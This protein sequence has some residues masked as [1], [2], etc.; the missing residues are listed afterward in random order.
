MENSQSPSEVSIETKKQ[1]LNTLAYLHQKLLS[2]Q[3]FP[4][5]FAEADKVLKLVMS[6]AKQLD[7]EIQADPLL[8]SESL[9]ATTEEKV[10]E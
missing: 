1:T 8:Q 10:S 9:N 4:E 6:M 7:A 3:F 5:E 2:V